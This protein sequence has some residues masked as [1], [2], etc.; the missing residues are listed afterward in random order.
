[1]V[2]RA[3]LLDK[4]GGPST[5]K[6]F[7]DQ[8]IMPIL[9]NAAGAVEGLLERVAVRTRKRPIHTLG[10]ALGLGTLTMLLAVPRRS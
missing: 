4:P 10:A 7:L 5:P 2:S 9:I 6:L 8:T 1:M 3:Y